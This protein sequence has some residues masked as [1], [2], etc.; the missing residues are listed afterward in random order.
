VAAL[1]RR[2]SLD[3]IVIHVSDWQRSTAFYADVL[4]AEIVPNPEGAGNP[5]GAVAYRFGGQQLNVHGPWPGREDRCCE[6]ADSGPPD[7][8]FVWTGTVDEA[9]DH[10]SACGVAVEEGPVERFGARGLGTSL[11]VRD[12]D[13]TPIELITYRP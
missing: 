5:I 12:P 4:G 11:Y 6:V 2:L 9:L 3:H 8:C 1:D 7:L 13:G 10:L